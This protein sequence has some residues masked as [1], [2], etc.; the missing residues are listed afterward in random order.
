MAVGFTPKYVEEY[1]LENFSPRHF[2]V[3]ANEAVKELTWQ[4]NYISPTG[5]I[6][7]TDN[8]VFSWNATI[9]IVIE[10]DIA[11]LKSSSAGNEMID[12]GRNKK[13]VLELVYE[14][15][16]A[17]TKYSAEELEA[18]YQEL[19]ASFPPA[20]DD[21]L[22]QPPATTADQINS[23][24]SVFKPTT[25]YFVT[26]I[27]VIA[28]I[29]V[30]VL[31]GIKG[32]GILMPETKDLLNWGADFGPY[33]LNGQWWRLL[34]SAFLHGG[35]MHLLFNMYALIYIGLLLEPYLGKL[36][37]ITAYILTALTA[38]M[39]SLW[40]HPETV[41]VGAS[42]AI[43]GMYGVFLAML[44]TNLIEK[45]TR[46]ALLTSIAVFVGYNLLYGVKAGIDNAA[47]IGGLAGGLVIGYCL[48]ISLKK[49]EDDRLNYRIC[50][51][52]AA[53]I[54][55]TCGWLYQN[56]PND[57]GQYDTYIK[58]FSQNEVN[59]LEIYKLKNASNPQLLTA[60]KSGINYWDKDVKILDKIDRLKLP[61][62]V[63]SNNKKLHRY[64]DLRIKSYEVLYK[65]VS[66]NTDKYKPDIE[67][68]NRQIQLS[69]DDLKGK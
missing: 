15:N 28:N 61:D 2:L 5:L 49:P 27:L 24:L 20:E 55:G 12:L 25:G 17:K 38:S 16:T 56:M 31:M 51:I 29:L 48:I 39:T 13:R 63:K 59:A 21:Y 11:T 65:G 58:E 57:L 1:S 7:Y 37:F 64:I 26:P 18:N 10:N 66:E 68:Y 45:S 47:H 67:N 62:V 69:L 36:R 41:S 4:V 54:I 46:K 50:G 19:K 43:F 34:S 22:Q 3:V 60:I 52:L 42:G 32:V 35:I 6:A 44:T 53:V 9:S 23:F 40:W 14:L 30:F 8:G 33:T